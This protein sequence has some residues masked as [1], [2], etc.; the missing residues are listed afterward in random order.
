M[1]A[2]VAALDSSCASVSDDCCTTQ[3]LL[4][5]WKYSINGSFSLLRNIEKTKNKPLHLCSCI[6]VEVEFKLKGEKDNCQLSQW[7]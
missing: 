7:R 1:N 3:L 2:A 4:D 5:D 6:Y